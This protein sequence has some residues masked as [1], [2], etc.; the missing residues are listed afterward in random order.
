[1][2]GVNN[3]LSHCDNQKYHRTQVSP[4]GAT[5][6]LVEKQFPKSTLGRNLSG[7]GQIKAAG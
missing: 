2:E 3:H 1:M 4:L 5:A 7:S 6:H